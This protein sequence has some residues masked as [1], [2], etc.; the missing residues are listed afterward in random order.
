MIFDLRLPMFDYRAM[1]AVLGYATML[2]CI[3]ASGLSVVAL[4]QIEHQKSQIEN[5]SSAGSISGSIEQGSGVATAVTAVDRSTGKRFTGKVADGRFRIDDLPIAGT[6]DVIIDFD[7]GRLEGVNMK[8][9]RSDYEKEQPLSHE[10]IQTIKEKVL[11]L[12][13]FE[14]IVQVLAIDGNIQHA[15]ILVN[16]LRTKPFYESKPGEIIW[17]P[18]LWHFERPEQ[19]WTKVQ[20]ELFVILYRERIQKSAFAKK[21]VTFDCSLGGVRFSEAATAVDL[22]MIAL[23][24]SKPGVRYRGVGAIPAAAASSREQP[25][26][27]SP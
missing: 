1:R 14:D 15:A 18:E 25:N 7:G 5:P 6:Y 12:N 20:D 10:D 19:T 17:R 27:E 4:P 9:P 21:S 16:K 23:P 22:G 24:E 8:V 26:G 3:A 2:L 11:S 13:Q